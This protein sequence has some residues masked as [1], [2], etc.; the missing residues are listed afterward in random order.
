MSAFAEIASNGLK[1]ITRAWK[2]D[3]QYGIAAAIATEDKLPADS[4]QQNQWLALGLNPPSTEEQGI[5]EI[6]GNRAGDVSMGD[7]MD[8]PAAVADKGKKSAPSVKNRSAFKKLAPYQPPAAFDMNMMMQMQQMGQ[9]APRPAPGGGPQPAQQQMAVPDDAPQKA[10]GGQVVIEG[11]P[12][13]LTAGMNPELISNKI[14]EIAKII[15]GDEDEIEV[16]TPLMQAGLTS[17]TAVILRDQLASNMP[18]VNL[19]PTLMFDYPS[20]QAITDF[21]GEKL[22]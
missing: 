22:G 16:D 12:L 20:I 17:N 18:G 4:A 5:L 7:D 3:R 2:G 1:A 13:Q 9:A 11:A 19:P 15:I 10:G 14:Q 21:I 6:W 8:A